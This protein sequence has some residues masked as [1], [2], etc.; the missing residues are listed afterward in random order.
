MARYTRLASVKA[1]VFRLSYTPPK[2]SEIPFRSLQ[3]PASHGII[4][5]IESKC[6]LPQGTVVGVLHL[7]YEIQDR[8]NYEA[9]HAI[10][11]S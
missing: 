6:L 9:D 11:H 4:Q 5:M 7:L 1:M 3:P 8:L 10:A 2:A